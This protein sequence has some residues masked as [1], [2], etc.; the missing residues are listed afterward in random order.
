MD[1]VKSKIEQLNGTVELDSE[2]GCSSAR[3][4]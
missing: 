3:R 2:P 4:C 1:I